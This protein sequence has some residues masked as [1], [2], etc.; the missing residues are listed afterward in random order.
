MQRFR[1]NYHYRG[2][3]ITLIPRME[4]YMWAC[5]Y[6]IMKSGRT[7]MDGSP[8][9]T[10]LSRQ[11]AEVGA[12]VH[13]PMSARQGSIGKLNGYRGETVSEAFTTSVFSRMIFTS[14]G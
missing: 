6:V 10:Y 8:S 7:E 5:Q 12:N 3:I 14:P 9:S 1:S 4:G 11:Q 13:R 2:R